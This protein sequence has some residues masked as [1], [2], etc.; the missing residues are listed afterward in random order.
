MRRPGS[1]RRVVAPQPVLALAAAPVQRPVRERFVRRPADVHALLQEETPMKYKPLGRTGLFVSELCLGTMTFGGSGDGIQCRSASFSRRKRSA[2][3]AARSMPASTSSTPPTSTPTAARKRSPARRSEPQGTARERRRRDQGL[4]RD[5]RRARTCAARRAAT[6][7]PA[8]QASLKRPAARSRRPVP[9]PRLRP[10]DADRGDGAC[11]RH[12]VQHGHVRYVGVSNW[13]AW[14]I[15]KALGIAER[16]GL[17][18]FE[19][20]RPT[21]RSPAATSSASWSRC[22]RAKASA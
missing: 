19:A 18:R 15:M 5:R 1:A 20:C 3:S 8:L 2:S 7:S 4:R 13:A 14:Q 21:T 12:L 17:A 16:L 9:D 22:C 10:G 6:S 11:A